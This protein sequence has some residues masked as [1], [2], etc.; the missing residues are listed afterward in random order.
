MKRWWAALLGLG[1]ATAGVHWRLATLPSTA[2]T[3][4]AVLAHFGVAFLLYLGACAAAHRLR[5]SRP[6]LV[7]VWCFVVAA[8]SAAPY[9]T[10]SLELSPEPDRFR[11]D[12]KVAEAGYNPYEMAPDDPELAPLRAEFDRPVPN[13]ERRGLY[14]PLAELLFY[15]LARFDA[16]SL[17]HYRALFALTALLCGGALLGLAHEAGVPM[18]RVVD[19]L[20]HPL[21]ILESAGGA[22]L[23][24]FPLLLLLVSLA[25]L[26][27]R[28]QL[29]PLATLALA[30]LA[31]AFPIALLPLYLRRIPS[32]RIL[33][34]FLVLLAGSLPFLGA[35]PR[36]VTGMGEYWSEA[37]FNPGPY[38][39]VEGLFRWVGEV[40]WT[41][42]LISIA[43]AGLALGLFLTDDGSGSSIIRR[44]FYLAI[45]PVVL[46]PVIHPWLLIWLL[47]FLALLDERNPFRAP[48]L[49]LSGAVML[50]YL[51]DLW[52]FIP[53]WVTW[54]EFGPVGLLLIWSLWRRGRA[55]AP[56]VPPGVD[57]C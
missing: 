13:P 6:A 21:L 22:H 57:A 27:A 9:L 46:G 34:F 51:G 18:V 38:L 32:Y 52:G 30:T 4:P 8:A 17:L 15:T 43:G 56:L 55:A 16:D 33:L 41:R 48:I 42:P 47:P 12:G 25:L 10:S 3:I 53:A 54:V 39:L 35:G 31:K 44:A 2:A 11:W 49:Y 23:E 50:S 29:T 5:A 19:L 36:L 28:H 45:P 1:L 20:W 24:S 14:P 40:Q 7:V 37:R 26:V